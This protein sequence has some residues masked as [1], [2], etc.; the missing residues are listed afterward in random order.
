MNIAEN[1]EGALQNMADIYAES[2][3]AASNRVRA[4][5]EGLWDSFINS[6]S[7]ISALDGLSTIIDSMDN[8]IKSY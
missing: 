4:S 3:E 8:L 7:F 2:W 1:S 5:W 6:D